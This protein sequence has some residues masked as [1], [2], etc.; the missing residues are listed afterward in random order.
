[1]NKVDRF[2]VEIR[3]AEQRSGGWAIVIPDDLHETKNSRE[4]GMPIPVV[5]AFVA[6]N[7]SEGMRGIFEFQS[8]RSR[9]GL[10]SDIGTIS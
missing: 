4:L 7:V 9:S 6:A 2:Y 10:P 5:T 3:P 8:T 1:M